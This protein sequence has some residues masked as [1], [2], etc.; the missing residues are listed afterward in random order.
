MDYA[1]CWWY[2]PWKIGIFHG[3][4]SL[5]EGVNKTCLL[6]TTYPLPHTSD[7]AQTDSQSFDKT[8]NHLEGKKRD[9]P[10]ILHGCRMNLPCHKGI[11]RQHV[12]ATTKISLQKSRL[13]YIFEA[14]QMLRVPQVKTVFFTVPME[15]AKNLPMELSKYNKQRHRGVP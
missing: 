15:V 3:Y 12:M 10:P 9:L 11:T 13:Q 6:P 8:R 5:P 4:V 2:L 14:H 1:P 7:R